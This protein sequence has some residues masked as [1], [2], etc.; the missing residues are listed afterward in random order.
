[1]S[2]VYTLL[3]NFRNSEYKGFKTN[4]KK[5]SLSELESNLMKS[6]RIPS[7]LPNPMGNF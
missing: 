4:L 1:M 6:P 7:I 3:I 5:K 2:K